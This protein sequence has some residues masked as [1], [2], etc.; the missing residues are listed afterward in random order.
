MYSHFPSNFQ[1]FGQDSRRMLPFID[2][3]DTAAAEVGN[4]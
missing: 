4:S 3:A 1:Y 2:F